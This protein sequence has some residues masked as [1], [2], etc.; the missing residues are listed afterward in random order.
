MFVRVVVL[1]SQL[2]QSR[3]RI[4]NIQRDWM[5]EGGDCLSVSFEETRTKGCKTVYKK[6]G[7]AATNLRNE[8]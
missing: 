8:Y 3:S 1:C 6:K 2:M 4:M 7:I 5:L